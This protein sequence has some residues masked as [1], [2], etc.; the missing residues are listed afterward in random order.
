MNIK[1]ILN[2]YPFWQIQRKCAAAS[3]FAENLDFSSVLFRNFLRKR[4][5]ETKS[6]FISGRIALIKSSENII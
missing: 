1:A 4:E 6:F 2:I 5:S 3:G